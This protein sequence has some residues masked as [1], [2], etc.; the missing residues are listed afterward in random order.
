MLRA[1]SNYRFHD[2]NLVVATAEA[3]VALTMHIDTALFVDAGSVAPKVEDL[4]LGRNQFAITAQLAK[5]GIEDVIIEAEFHVW[6][7]N[8]SKENLMKRSSIR[9]SLVFAFAAS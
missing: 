4:R 1:Y 2:R 6:G 3:R 7:R 5:I 9:Q 8:F